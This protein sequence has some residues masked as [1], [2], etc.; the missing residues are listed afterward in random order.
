MT[1]AKRLCAIA[2]SV[3]LSLLGCSALAGQ[4]E[5]GGKLG[6]HHVSKDHAHVPNKQEFQL[7]P[8]YAIVANGDLDL[9]VH[10][11]KPYQSVELENYQELLTHGRKTKQQRP[12][13]WVDNGVLYIDNENWMHDGQPMHININVKDLNGLFLTGNI[14]VVG[15]HITSN[16]M[17]IDDDSTRNVY[18]DGVMTLNWLNSRNKGD[19]DVAWVRGNNFQMLGTGSGLIRLAGAVHNMHVR[20]YNKQKYAGQFLRTDDLMIQTRDDAEANVFARNSQ[21]SYAYDWSN[22]FYFTTPRS[23]NRMTEGSGNILQADWRP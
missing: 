20:L 7:S 4:I 19:I 6:R 12:V 21:E 16:G 11:S 17:V 22:I 18:L 5:H 14:M 3:C 13:L 23:I 8:F 10:G 1:L 2:S 15:D 9:F